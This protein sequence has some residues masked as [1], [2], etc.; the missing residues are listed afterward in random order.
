MHSLEHRDQAEATYLARGP[1]SYDNFRNQVLGAEPEGAA[2]TELF[3]DAYFTGEIRLGPYYLINAVAIQHRSGYFRPAII[4]RSEQ[5]PLEQERDR[6]WYTDTSTYHGGSV[7]DEIA[8]MVALCLGARLQAGFT[9][10]E[11]VP[12]GD[13]R[14]RPIA[15]GSR[16]WPTSTPLEV[17]PILPWAAGQHELSD[18]NLGPINQLHRLSASDA[19]TLVKAARTYQRATWMA[20][21]D[22]EIAWLLLVSAIEAI[23]SKQEWPADPVEEFRRYH[24]D[25]ADKLRITGGCEMLENV[26]RLVHHDQRLARR[27]RQFII[28][29]GPQAPANRPSGTKLTWTPKSI[30][31]ALQKVYDHR[32][33]ALHD[34]TP[35]PFPICQ[36]PARVS[37]SAAPEE[38]PF[39]L[40]IRAQGGTWY[41]R[42]LPMYL[43]IFEYLVRGAILNWWKS[44]IAL[45]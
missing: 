38:A 37:E 12:N 40:A 14:G 42:E 30:A 31:R 26:V 11:F 7:A 6:H 41:Q 39:M 35:F 44:R 8:A 3:S 9:T 25:L 36:P 28:K 21:S 27:F 29:F 33:R 5:Y 4:L 17:A 22:P 20:D 32:S 13:P 19:A 24:S 23:T 43:H 2:E 15:Y 10:R 16:P 1:A 45:P 18:E 34:G